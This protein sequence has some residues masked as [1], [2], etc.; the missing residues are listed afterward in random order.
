M[1][2]RSLQRLAQR[3]AAGASA[4]KPEDFGDLRPELVHA[5]RDMGISR[6]NAVQ[7]EA[8]TLSL[9]GHADQIVV[10]Q[11]GSGKT[12]I[13]LL[14]LLQR[15]AE[16]AEATEAVAQGPAAPHAIVLAP[17]AALAMQHASIAQQLA[18]ELP[19]ITVES[20]ARLQSESASGRSDECPGRDSS[21]PARLLV[22]TPKQLLGSR[23]AHGTASMVALDECDALLCGRNFQTGLSATGA[24]SEQQH[25]TTSDSTL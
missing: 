3:S 1:L 14:P 22:G 8:L 18:T 11:T 20:L 5:L 9:S 19:S 25:S 23:E 2:R 15:L 24:T 16:M 6:L 12:L 7:A 17:T 13:F 10:A 4:A 21:R